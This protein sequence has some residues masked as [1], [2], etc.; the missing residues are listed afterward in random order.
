MKYSCFFFLI[1]IVACSQPNKKAYKIKAAQNLRSADLLKVGSISRLVAINHQKLVNLS[2]NLNSFKK[3]LARLN[4]DDPASIP[5]ALDYIK[6]CISPTL[7]E[8][9]SVLLLFNLKFYKTSNK[10]SDS[11]ETKYASVVKLMDNQQNSPRLMNFKNNLKACGIGIFS[12]E[13]NYYFDMPSDYLYKN[14]EN[15]VSDGVKAYLYLRKGEL[16]AGFSED[17]GLLISFD[18]LYRRIKQWEKFLKDYPNTVY[19]EE[20]NDYYITYLQTLLTGM[21]NSRI[22][23][24][25]NNTLCLK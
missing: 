6:T 24:L 25:E 11:L 18:A 3:Y 19:S 17:A 2:G 21:D 1:L 16:A 5:F 14:F 22:F 12:T 10:L 13:G 7:P 15:R 9:D 8:K 4:D 23:D 20:A